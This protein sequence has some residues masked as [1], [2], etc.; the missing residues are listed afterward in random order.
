MDRIVEPLSLMGARIHAE[1]GKPPVKITGTDRR[2]RA[3]RYETPVPSAQVKTSILFAGLAA[4]GETV[5]L[6]RTHTRDHGELALRAFGAEVSRTRDTISIRGGQRLQAIEASIPGD[7]SSASFFLCASALFPDSNLVVEDVL[8]NPTRAGILDV[9]TAMGARVRVIDLEDRRGELVGRVK[10][11]HA[12]LKG[13]KISGALAGQL[14]DELPVLA[15][16]APYTAEGV[17]IRDARE[18]RVK[19][20]DRIAAVAANLKKMGAQ[21]TEHEDG[22]SVPGGQSLHGAELDSFGDHRI[23]MAF[24]VSA[25]RAEGDSL[26]HGAEAASIS[27]PGFWQMLEAVAER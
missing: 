8:L 27:F 25:L 13:A 18:L 24:A 5:L 2:L 10:V 14:I 21:V 12:R 16:I 1:A 6:E 26:I 17:E 4:D 20:S 7:V 3:I 19:E 11:E 23:A 15:A 9:L 22:L